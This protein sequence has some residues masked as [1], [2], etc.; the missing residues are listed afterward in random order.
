MKKYAI[1]TEYLLSAQHLPKAVDNLGFS[2]RF[3]HT[4]KPKMAV[5]YQNGVV[6]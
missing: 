1:V 5:L 3:Q 2:A 4:K 6:T